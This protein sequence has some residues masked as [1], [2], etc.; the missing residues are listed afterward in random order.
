MQPV[1]LTTLRA[2]CA[3]LQ[4]WLPARLETVY[5]RDR[6]TI[7]LALRTLK[8]QDW[9]T[10]SWH[11]QA[12]RIAFEP[13]P[14]RQ[15][16]TFTFSQQLHAQLNRLALVRVGL[17]NPWERVL[18][19]E[20]APRPQAATQWRLYA[21]IMG[22]YSNVILVNAAGE[23]VTAAHQVN[24][25]QSRL[26][27][28]L[29]GQPYV[30]PPPLT[31]ALP[32]CEIPFEQWQQQVSVIPGLLRQQLLKAYRGLS[33][34]FVQQLLADA[35]LSLES[36]TTELTAEEWRRLFDHWQHWLACLESGH[37][38]PQLTSTG[39]RVIPPL[40]TQ[41]QPTATIHELLATYYQDQ[42]RQQQT[43]QLRQQLHQSLQAQRQKLIAKIEGFRERLAAAA[44]GDRQRYLAD[45]LMAHAH[46]WQPGM[47]K[48]IVTDFATQEPLAIP[49]SPEKS[50]I[51]TAQELYKQQ[52]KLKRAQQHI[53]PL[54]TAAEEELA[55]LDQV[56]ATLTTATSLDVLEEI[57]AE[58]IQQGYLTAPD[59][60]RPPTTP[61]PYLRYTT[62]SGFTVL[63]G[64]NNRQN[65][66]LTF[67]VASPYDWWFHTQEIPG[68]H[69]ILR[70]EAG[71]VP[72]EKDIQYV[73][74]LA[75]YHSQARASAQVPVVYT[76][77]KYVQKP[78]GANPGMVIYDQATVVWGCPL[79]VSD[80][81]SDLPQGG[82]GGDR[83]GIM[84][85]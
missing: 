46:L 71:E 43:Q 34:A 32:S 19:L 1:D 37:F 9:L 3:D 82:A 11:P 57:R 85:E 68:S 58:L 5:Q 12:A 66:D 14:P 56:A 84:A 33:P 67:R 48:L 30:P 69:V 55:Y 64:R 75:A 8:K 27:P 15:P 10:L 77:R 76:C 44:G 61:S 47:T 16:D 13:P 35:A 18:V 28:I 51:Q 25:Q 62:P 20:F 83:H 50:A 22:K 23:I 26:R 59:Y 39:Y 74:N 41:S 70:L 31:A 52:Q 65:D 29:T 63:V 80:G 21:E 45:L 36:H 4:H 49:L 7:A 73:A 17:V 42:L 38:V 78:K 40:G 60:Y 24:A 54:L 53:T 2:V 72:S 79:S 81:S 6:H